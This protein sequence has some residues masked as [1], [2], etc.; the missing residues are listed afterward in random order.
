MLLFIAPT[1]HWYM[2]LDNKTRGERSFH[3][4]LNNERIHRMARMPDG[5]IGLTGTSEEPGG[6]AQKPFIA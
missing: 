2:P 6:I 3:T 5:N 1:R 4:P